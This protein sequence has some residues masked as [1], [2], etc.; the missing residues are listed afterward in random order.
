M[1]GVREAALEDGTA[2][3]AAQ[4]F[5]REFGLGLDELGTLF[6][7]AKWRHSCG[8]QAW[9]DICS[10]VQELVKEADSRDEKRFMAALGELETLHHNTGSA[11][12]KLRDLLGGMYT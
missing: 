9:A 4:V 10:K 1:K 12:R 7:T 2:R 3:G 5:A 8:G 6:L 11:A